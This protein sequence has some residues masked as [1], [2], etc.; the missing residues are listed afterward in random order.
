M[1]TYQGGSDVNV[2]SL[3]DKV[4]AVTGGG[5]GLGKQMVLALASFGAKVAIIDKDFPS[6]E[7]LVAELQGRPGSPRAVAFATDVTQKSEVESTVERICE[8]F[9][10][11][12][13]LVN[14]AGITRRSDALSMSEAD[15]DEVLDVN[16]KGVFLCCQAVG[17]K[18]VGQ[19]TGKIINIASVVG[20]RG[21]F[22]PLDYA[23][24]YCAS[25]GGVIQLTRTLAA[26]WAKYNVLV[27]AI[28]PTYF[29]TDMTRPLLENS[30][31]KEY[32][33]WKI[34]LGRPGKLEE[35]VGPVVFFASEAS[36]MVTGQVLNVD[37][38]WTAI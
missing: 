17:R 29:M 9:E 35:L 22:H 3:Q 16:L 7:K 8:V 26:E 32:L 28:A 13:I 19:G 24:S 2:F 4:A 5:K 6:A 37:G 21:L 30:E 18:M 10:R 14:C 34:P 36:N 12:D 23:T 15:W 31:F 38:G 25:K 27:N 1:E 20:Q 33:K 11:I